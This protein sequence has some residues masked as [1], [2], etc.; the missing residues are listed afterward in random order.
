MWKESRTYGLFNKLYF[1]IIH[2]GP[3]LVVLLSSI[4]GRLMHLAVFKALPLEHQLH[5]HTLRTKLEAKYLGVKINYDLRWD[6]HIT[7]VCKKANK[8]LVCTINL[9]PLMR[10]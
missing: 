7:D 4:R 8:T 10:G 3:G 1:L 9:R 6:A 5:G 2:V